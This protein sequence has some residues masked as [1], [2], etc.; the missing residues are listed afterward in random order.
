MVFN[1]GKNIVVLLAV[2]IITDCCNAN[3]DSTCNRPNPPSSE[4]FDYDRVGHIVTKV[5]LHDTL[6]NAIFDTGASELT[7]DTSLVD[8]ANLN[9]RVQISYIFNSQVSNAFKCSS[10]IN[11]KFGE[12]TIHYTAYYVDNVI[13]KF[14]VPIIFT[15]PPT[16]KKTWHIDYALRQLEIIDVMPDIPIDSLAVVSDVKI[17]NGDMHVVIPFNF[18]NGTDSIA[19]RLSGII[20]TGNSKGI[21]EFGNTVCFN[22]DE[23]KSFMSSIQT[24]NLKNG[25]SVCY[26]YD[27]LLKEY[28]RTAFMKNS[29]YSALVFGNELLA[30]YNIYIDMSDKKFYA[31]NSQAY[32]HPYEIYSENHDVNMFVY[33]TDKG[34]LVDYVAKQTPY[35]KSGIRR[36]DIILSI[37]GIEAESLPPDIGKRLAGTEK[38]HNIAIQRNADTLQ[39]VYQR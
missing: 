27:N 38:I 17:S 21:V 18:V 14:G 22:S 37:D 1:I 33:K 7:L 36:G 15:I 8:M 30:H 9:E 29:N 28:I 25:M 16:S 5:G 19:Y 24:H 6:Y 12:D 26:L 39:L 32:K 11:L 10:P 20:D 13:D 23:M 34:M 2:C 3:G 35:Y 4:P 31:I